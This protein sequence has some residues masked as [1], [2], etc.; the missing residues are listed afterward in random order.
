MTHIVARIFP[1]KRLARINNPIA[2]LISRQRPR[3][4]RSRRLHWR[5]RMSASALE[6]G[7]RAYS[8]T[9]PELRNRIIVTKL[10]ENDDYWPQKRRASF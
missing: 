2:F 10:T 6:Q 4:R 5:R 8:G 7:I 3:R 9:P 1:T